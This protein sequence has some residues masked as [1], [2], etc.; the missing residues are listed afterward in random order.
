MKEF[1]KK[2]L[3]S[4]QEFSFLCNH[5]FL[6][7]R[8]WCQVNYYYDTDD[9]M[10]SAHGITCRIREQDGKFT[11]TVKTHAAA[12]ADC[13]VETSR[14][15]PGAEMRFPLDHFH[16]KRRGCLVTDRRMMRLPNGIA[17]MLDSNQYLGITDYEMEI[18]YPPA[19]YA[20][21]DEVLNTVA[22]KLTWHAL[23]PDK[24]AFLRR[25]GKNGSKSQRFFA[26]LSALYDDDSCI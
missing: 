9:L 19:A 20:Q 15:V 18:E 24:S 8:R 21:A 7:E 25:V 4:A 17:V 14:P 23:V 2:V 3:L 5:F 26:R 1:E 16:L 6:G 12:N 13:S 10:L 11:Q 22:S